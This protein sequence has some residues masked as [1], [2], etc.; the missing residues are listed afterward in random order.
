MKVRIML[1]A[2]LAIAL[3]AAY[4]Q[5][6]PTE[7]DIKIRQTVDKLDV[8]KFLIAPVTL[9]AVAALKKWVAMIPDKWLPWTAP[10]I[11]AVLDQL[12]AK[13]GLWTGDLAAGAALGGLATWAHQ[14][15]I[16]QP[17]EVTPPD[18]DPPVK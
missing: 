5:V 11:G 17:K 16:V 2:I 12:A 7:T 10:L 1:L 13:F 3:S 8:W 4:A 14:A 9:I 18:P 15:M 6:E